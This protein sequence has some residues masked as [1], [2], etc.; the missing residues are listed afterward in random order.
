MVDFRPKPTALV[1]DYIVEMQNGTRIP[2]IPTASVTLLNRITQIQLDK[3][4]AN[5]F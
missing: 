2:K 5:V 1:M 4:A 3:T